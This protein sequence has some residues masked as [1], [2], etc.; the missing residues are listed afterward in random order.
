M[1]LEEKG[2]EW[3]EQNP[4]QLGIIDETFNSTWQRMTNDVN[5]GTTKNSFSPKALKGDEMWCGESKVQ[6][7]ITMLPSSQHNKKRSFFDE[8]N[9]DSSHLS[10][11]KH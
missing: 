8:A 5:T 4:V 7:H 2:S 10:L 1:V 6:V 11:S 3:K 9:N